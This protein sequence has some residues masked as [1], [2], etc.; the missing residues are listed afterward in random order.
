VEA[1]DFPFEEQLS[2]LLLLPRQVRIE[3]IEYSGRAPPK[4]VSIQSEK[5]PLAAVADDDNDDV[6]V[7]AEEEE[8]KPI[9]APLSSTASSSSYLDAVN[10]GEQKMPD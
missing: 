6:H 1:A 9:S 2:C 5:H 3:N 4:R 10:R 7:R 8:E